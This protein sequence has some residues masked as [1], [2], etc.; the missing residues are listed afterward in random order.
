MKLYHIKYGLS[1]SFNAEA[2]DW[3]EVEA[4]SRNEAEGLAYDYACEEYETYEGMYGLRT[5]EDIMKEE[6]YDEDIAY[7]V[8][9]EERADWLYYEVL[10]EE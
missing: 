5:V 6:G 8:Y 3:E 1:G 4:S 2:N 10:E 7:D 9:L